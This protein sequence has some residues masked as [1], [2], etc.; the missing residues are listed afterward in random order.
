MLDK[1][2]EWIRGMIRANHA[3]NYYDVRGEALERAFAEFKALLMKK[4]GCRT[5]VHLNEECK[6]IVGIK[7]LVRELDGLKL[8]DVISEQ[9]VDD[10]FEMDGRPVF[11]AA[12]DQ[13]A[14]AG[15][16]ETGFLPYLAAVNFY[17]GE[18]WMDRNG[19]HGLLWTL[20]ENSAYEAAARIVSYPSF[21][22]SVPK[23]HLEFKA[24][25]LALEYRKI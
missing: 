22:D 5:D 12:R 6:T 13:A 4:E 18:N 2:Y 17:L 11:N 3:P 16:A 9:R 21:R 1:V 25:L 24:A 7:H 15:I 20:I 10:L 19:R 8:G 14:R 23:I